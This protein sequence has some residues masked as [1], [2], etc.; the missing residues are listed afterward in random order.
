MDENN[1]G[2]FFRVCEQTVTQ[3]DPNSCGISSTVSLLNT[4]EVDP[5]TN[6]KGIWR[7]YDEKTLKHA[8]DK[9]MFCLLEIADILLNNDVSLKTFLPL[10]P[11]N[12]KL[13][14]THTG[15]IYDLTR[16][17]LFLEN[18]FC[19][20][21]K[22]VSNLHEKTL[23]KIRSPEIEDLLVTPTFSFDHSNC[24]LNKQLMTI[25]QLSL[26][27]FRSLLSFLTKRD[28]M[29]MLMNFSRKSLGQTGEGHFSPIGAFCEAQDMVLIHEVARFKYSY[30]WLKVPDI[31]NALCDEDNDT[32]ISRGLVVAANKFQ[33]A[34]N[35][36]ESFK[37][38]TGLQ[39]N[40]TEQLKRLVSTGRDPTVVLIEALKLPFFTEFVWK[41]LLET[42]IACDENASFRTLFEAMNQEIT[43]QTDL[44]TLAETFF[45][46][47]ERLDR[48]ITECVPLK[49]DSLKVLLLCLLAN[50]INS[51]GG[52]TE[53]AFDS[54]LLTGESSRKTLEWTQKFYFN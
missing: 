25:S 54:S 16:E 20:A 48:V 53:F 30:H 3:K 7:W 14:P 45:R 35:L 11:K 42:M 22:H 28:D 38:R 44:V 12:A 49:K 5:G 51:S 10:D 13:R 50:L 19:P 8:P 46:H 15:C 32:H 4:L 29:F 37:L 23:S 1:L 47:H 18:S 27:T 6:W 39:S 40:R 43:K 36:L 33:F 17:N 9:N 41:F 24:V 26:E 31:Y 34:N 2:M 21:H 52:P